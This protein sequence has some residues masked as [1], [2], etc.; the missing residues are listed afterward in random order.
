FGNFRL[1]RSERLLLGPGGPV[2][3]SA[4]SFDILAMLLEKPD[5]VIGKTELFET[6]WPGLV[7]EEN[8]LQVHV[9]ALR[10]LLP[11][12]MIVTVHGRGYKY[13]GP[14]P[15]VTTAEVFSLPRASIAVLPFVNM[16]SDAEYEYFADGVAEDIITGLGR[17]RSLCVIS[18]K[19]SF[20]YKG[21][22]ENV[23]DIGLELAAQ[24]I[25]EGS[26]RRAAERVRVTAQL[27]ETET[28]KHLWAERFDRDIGDIFGVQDDIVQRI[29]ASLPQHVEGAERSRN[30]QRPAE[31]FSAYDHWLRGK[32]VLNNGT[33][34]EEVLQARRHFERA[35]ELDP[36][37]ASAY[38]EL[39][40]SFYAEHESPWTASREAAA[41]RI[42]ELSRKA[43]E[44][45]PHDSRTHLE[46]AWSYLHVK[47]DLDLA[48]IQVEIALALNPNDYYNYCVVGWL[49]AC[50]GDLAHAV[51][52][53]NEALRRSPVVADS[54]LEAR[55][56]AEY[57]AGDY[58][59]AIVAF[60]RI[61]RP[62]M[63]F[64]AW[65]A[66]TYAQLGRTDQARSL[67]DIFLKHAG[68][69]PWAPKV[70]DSD[71]WRRYWANE[72]QTKDPAAFGLLLDGLRKAGLTT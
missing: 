52:S 70:D 39:A 65:A 50:S 9:S 51:A 6:V 68:E 25:V 14:K 64:Y 4:R 23:R 36:G 26:V 31:S 30:L 12:E 7:V 57:L 28:G 59:E 8:T 32:Y 72:F 1:K 27:V 61:L 34:M 71:G 48:R 47:G 38:V 69:L 67:R 22:P 55:L 45:D 56:V 46:L 15:S 37:Y 10:K 58:Q 21:R 19:S 63:A 33:S 3:L 54:C 11:A 17:F 20:V 49:S 29:V 53:S 18:R 2:E 66:A 16:S 40:E 44:L 5:E 43:V 42:F 13:A 62:R 41:E 60:S 35:I 24:Y